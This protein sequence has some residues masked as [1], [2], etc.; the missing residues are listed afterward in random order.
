[1]YEASGSFALLNLLDQAA[2]RARV[3]G[4]SLWRLK[5]SDGSVA[6]EWDVDWSLAPQKRRQALRLYCPNG[7]VA[8]LGDPTGAD[9]TDRLFQLKVAAICAGVGRATLA[10]II[11]IVD[12]LNGECQYAAWLYDEGR[13]AT[14]RSNVHD[15]SYEGHPVGPLAFEHLGLNPD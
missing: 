14:G 7:Q 13:L 5:Y 15:F 4:R 2:L 3:Q 11:G 10:H 6:N 9:A 12:G 1:L 8:E